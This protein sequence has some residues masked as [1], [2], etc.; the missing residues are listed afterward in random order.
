M[1]KTIVVFIERAENNYSAFSNDLP[2][3]VAT[4]Q[5]IEE[6]LENMSEAIRWHLEA[7]AE[8]EVTKHHYFTLESLEYRG[9][10]NMPKRDD[11]LIPA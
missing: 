6:T 4:G 2:G 7:M 3:C 10:L 8:E 9:K 11:S 1:G 5:T